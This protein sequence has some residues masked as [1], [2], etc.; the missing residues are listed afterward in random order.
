M[1]Y[2]HIDIDAIQR[3]VGK[4]GDLDARRAYPSLRDWSHT[5]EARTSIWHAGQTLRAARAVKAYQLRGF[6]A[7]A[8]YHAALVLWVYGLLQCGE[9]KQHEAKTPMSE[10]DL[11]PCVLLDGP[12]DKVTKAFLG[13]GIGRP[14]LTMTRGGP[15]E[16]TPMFCELSKPRSVM[17]IAR[18]IFEGNC[19]CPFPEDRLPPMIQNLCELIEDLGNLP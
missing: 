10:T 1:M 15:D 2:L 4:L 19:P 13:H 17:A 3:F 9:L 6:D 14:G 12:E 8:I 11:P 16:D 7:M 5:K 18:Q